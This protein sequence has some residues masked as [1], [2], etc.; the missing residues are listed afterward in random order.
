MD[1]KT[2][3]TLDATDL[4]R[5]IRAREVETDELVA[6]AR[7]ANDAVNPAINAV[8][9][10]YTDVDANQATG[11]VFSGV[12]FLRKDLGASEAGRLQESGSRLTAGQVADLD[13]VY[14]ERARTAGLRFVG[15]S[16]TP[17]FGMAG[18]TESLLNGIT[19]NPWNL[20]RTAGGS[21]GGAAAAV[22]AGVVPIAHASDGGGSIRIPAACCGLI[23]LNPSRGRITGAPSRQ[24]SLFGL[25]REFVVCRSVRDAAAALDALA[26]PGLGDPF[27]IQ[28]P[29]RSYVE[30]FAAPTEPLRIG[31]CRTPWGETG[32]VDDVAVALEDAARVLSDAGHE[33]VEIDRPAPID[34]VQRAVNG[35]FNLGLVGLPTLAHALDRRL[36]DSFLEPV[37][38]QLYELARGYSSAEVSAIFEAG[39][40]LR[41]LVGQLFENVDLLLTPT[42]P[43]PAEFHGLYATTNPALSAAEFMRGDVDLF[44]FLGI[45]NVTGQP[46]IS[47][48]LAQSGDDLPIGLQ[49]VARFADEDLLIR[50]ARDL[51]QAMP[52]VERLPPHHVSTMSE[53]ADA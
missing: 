15:R 33:L 32:I 37:T 24:D 35:L 18:F 50:I 14:V 39:R 7:R 42:L 44:Q 28:T 34:L 19:R 11:G 52:W 10:F 31:V 26:G 5:R 20:E 23:G 43:R 47:L 48:P 38:L 27:V 25:A 29:A 46:S 22:A 3:S 21:S 45:F 2:Y 17:E 12:P 9:E 30:A 6:C 16:A 40:E 49:L 1:L 8:I 4:G 51:E 53:G 36:D 41:V 13:S